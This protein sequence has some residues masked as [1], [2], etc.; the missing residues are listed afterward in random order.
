MA[1]F[2]NI[3]LSINN[4]DNN[5]TNPTTTTTSTIA[6]ASVHETHTTLTGRHSQQ[7]SMDNLNA[8]R[9]RIN[10]FPVPPLPRDETPG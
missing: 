2:Q 9:S 8:N 1:N 10:S 7:T 6:V 3:H 5:N 4:L